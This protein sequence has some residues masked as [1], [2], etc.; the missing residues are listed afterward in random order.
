MTGKDS[1]KICESTLQFIF[2]ANVLSKYPVSYWQC[3]QCG[4]VQTD[5]PFWLDEAYGSAI[6]SADVGLVSRNMGNAD[7]LECIINNGF[8]PAKKFIDYAGGYG[9][10]VRMMRDKG[11]DFY[12]QDKY[13]RNLFAETFDIK[14]IEQTTAQPFELLTA[15]EVFE[16]L[17]DPWEEIGKMFFYSK[18]ILFSTALLPDQKITRPDDWWYFIPET[19]QHIAFY[20]EASLHIIAKR[21]NTTYHKINGNLHL[22]TQNKINRNLLQSFMIS[23]AWRTIY[24]KV[25]LKKRTSLLGPDHEKMLRKM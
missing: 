9:M 1:C 16:H 15:F 24:K 19:G 2:Q 3:T 11:Y 14:D 18:N 10:L 4:F 12:R 20:T 22:F 5:E 13:C 8:D 21:F 17:V 25:F 23:L 6:S 7:L